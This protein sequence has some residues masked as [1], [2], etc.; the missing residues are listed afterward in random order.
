V[1]SAAF[2]HRD[3]RDKPGDDEEM[4]RLVT[5]LFPSWPGSSRHPDRKNAMPRM[6]VITGTRPMMTVEL[7]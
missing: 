6:I 3:H 7:N 4:E 5:P 1:K 2:R